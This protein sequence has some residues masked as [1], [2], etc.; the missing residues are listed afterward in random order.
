MA[1]G[2]VVVPLRRP[3]QAIES[4]QLVPEGQLM[5]FPKDPTCRLRGDFGDLMAMPLHRT[6]S[7]RVQ[8]GVFA[9]PIKELL[10]LEVTLAGLCRYGQI[11]RHA[12]Q[13]AAPM[14]GGHGAGPALRLVELGEPHWAS[15]EPIQQ[16]P[17]LTI[18]FARSHEH[19]G[20]GNPVSPRE[21]AIRPR[22]NGARLLQSVLPR[23]NRVRHPGV[24]ITP[25]LVSP[26]GTCPGPAS[27]RAGRPT[28]FDW[29]GRGRGGR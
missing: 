24:C 18:L 21:G 7:V 10:E 26:G 9:K 11:V 8:S 16:V 15:A 4:L 3:Q 29:F 25:K 5:T 12:I 14:L 19:G 17:R 27:A 20:L 2:F 23:R 13:E 1:E 6:G 22:R 28:R